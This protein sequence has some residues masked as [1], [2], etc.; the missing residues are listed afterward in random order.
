MKPTVRMILFVLVMAVIT[1]GILLGVEAL[2]AERIQNNQDAKIKIAILESHGIDYTLA[3]INETFDQEIDI[4]VSGDWT[5]Y[6]N[7]DTN[8]VSFAIS[9]GGVWGPI[10]GILTLESDFETILSVKILQQEETPG[11]GGVIAESQYL[12]TFVGKKMLPQ[13]EINKDTAPNLPNEIDSIVGA[14]NT[15][16]RFQ[17]IMN[18]DYTQARLAWLLQSQLGV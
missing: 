1:S 9:G 11:L 13:F 12:A 16:K 6:V 17:D 10:E 14:T 2:T 18:D 15:S 8:A 5:F 7:P 4:I 3:T